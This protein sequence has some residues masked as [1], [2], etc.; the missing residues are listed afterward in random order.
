[1]ITLL[2]ETHEKVLMVEASKK[3][4]INDYKETFEPALK[5]LIDQYGRIN[6][7]MCFLD[8]FEG[9]EIEAIWEDAKFSVSHRHDFSKI[10]LVGMPRKMEWL[11]KVGAHL[12][13]FEVHTYDQSQRKDAEEWVNY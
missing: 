11:T 6:L 4:T 7:L 8:D 1:M 9:Y 5:K 12:V 3:L 10:A 2:P 13:D